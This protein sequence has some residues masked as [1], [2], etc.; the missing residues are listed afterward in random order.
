MKAQI[1]FYIYVDIHFV[2]HTNLDVIKHK[3]LE[4]RLLLI[5]GIT[6]VFIDSRYGYS[7][8]YSSVI[9]KEKMRENIID[10]MKNYFDEIQGIKKRGKK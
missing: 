3:I 7:I 4:A 1:R 8:F 10:C 9:T 6:N 2:I 5:P